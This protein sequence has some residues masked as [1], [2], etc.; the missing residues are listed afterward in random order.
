MIN[1]NFKDD[2][3]CDLALLQK[4]QADPDVSQAKLAE[5]LGVAVGTVNWHLQRLVKKGYIKV[6]RAR[7]RKL[8]YIITPEGLSLRARLTLAYVQHSFMLF[9]EVRHHVRQL[10]SDLKEAEI[11]SVRLVGDGDIADV[12]R[13]TCMEQHFALTEN[14]LAPALVVNGLDVKLVIDNNIKKY[15]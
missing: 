3:F 1:I 6:K 7:R 13:L 10:L 4:V 12:C 14:L 15:N 9:R 8:R 2:K 11:H 5:D